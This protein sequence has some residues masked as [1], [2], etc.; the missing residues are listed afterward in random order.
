M[1]GL[2]AHFL[3]RSPRWHWALRIAIKE[4]QAAVER[5]EGKVDQIARLV[6]AERLG[7]ALG[8][9]RTLTSLV[10]RV[11]A[12]REISATDWSSV[13][14]LGPAIVEDIEALRV[15]IRGELL[16]AKGGW[17]TRGRADDVMELL[18][19]DLVV[20][21]IGLLVVAEHNLAEWQNLRVANVRSREP[22]HLESVVA[23]AWESLRFH[24]E[25]DQALLDELRRVGDALI[26]PARHDG[27]APIQ[28]QRLHRASERLD[29]LGSWFAE[30]RTLDGGR[31][32]LDGGA[33][34]AADEAGEAVGVVDGVVVE[35]GLDHLALVPV[36]PAGPVLLRSSHLGEPGD[37]EQVAGAG[38][39][40]RGPGEQ[41]VAEGDDD[42]PAAEL[43]LSLP[44]GEQ[45]D[46][47]TDAPM[48]VRRR[49]EPRD[50]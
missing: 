15:Y 21:S 47:L 50:L 48:L 25:Q 13:A 43:V 5:V 33:G 44:L 26:T 7:T 49:I 12:D 30:Q 19:E 22:E 24:R 37:E 18:D 29:E 1:S 36:E 11:D 9:H 6:R 42:P 45:L 4:V 3:S 40:H 34:F 28:S 17:R 35:E 16:E 39:Q 46:D 41:G 20:E 23:D 8:N 14:G 27:L 2:S 31:E 10:R 32:L 38:V